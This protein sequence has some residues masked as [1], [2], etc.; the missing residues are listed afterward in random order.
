VSRFP[1]LTRALYALSAARR[2]TRG[3]WR[4]HAI[5]VVLV[6]ALLR[7]E[8]RRRRAWL[9][10]TLPSGAARRFW[11]ADL[12]QV[13]ALGE[14]L[15]DGDYDIVVE[16]EPTT[17]VDLGSNAGQAS[18]FLRDRY[19][20]ASI[21][22]VEADPQIAA[23]TARNLGQDATVVS[24]AVSDHDGSATLTRVTGSSW[25]STLLS[26]SGDSHGTER[27][28]VRAVTL[29]TLLREQG[30]GEVDLLKVDVE[31]AELIALTSDDAL[32]QVR[33][34][35]GEVH[36]SLL[37]ISAQEAM[38]RLQDH[39]AFDRGWLHRPRVVVL[40]RDP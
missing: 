33:C 24:A 31:G 21:I 13:V 14:V 11:F 18:M 8:L 17:I 29:G 19:P 12:S 15:V 34:V 40:A 9:R 20:R 1:S 16:P 37:G 23:L 27:L 32:A 38:R 22:A 5:V 26:M 39:G 4:A 2:V 36:P 25:A 7:G 6:A 28:E 35:V 10:I 3:V 30:L